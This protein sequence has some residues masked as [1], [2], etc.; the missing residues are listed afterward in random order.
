LLKSKFKFSY[1]TEKNKQQHGKLKYISMI[2]MYITKIIMCYG[3][4]KKISGKKKL[5]NI[6]VN[7]SNLIC[8]IYDKLLKIIIN[9]KLNENILNKYINSYLSLY[10]N[11]EGRNFIRKS[12]LPFSKWYV[13]MFHNISKYNKIIKSIEN[14]TTKNLNKNLKSESKNII[15]N[16]T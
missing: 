6:K 3:L 12:L 11:K 1:L 8:G 10:N 14:N 4:D 16:N 5:E 15:I 7:S 2:M 13:K 9:G